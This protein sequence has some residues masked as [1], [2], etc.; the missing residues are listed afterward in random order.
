MSSLSSPSNQHFAASHRRIN[1][2]V[3]GRWLLALAATPLLAGCLS[4]EGDSDDGYGIVGWDDG[5]EAGPKQGD[6]APNFRL[7]AL[8][9]PDRTLAGEVAAGLPV[10]LN[11]FATWCASC[12]A[13][14]PVLDAA[15]GVTATVIG[16]DLR[17]AAD[18]VRPLV[19]ETGIRYPIL[20]DRDGA[21]ARALNAIALPTTCV[22]AADGTI[23]RLIV[24]PLTAAS[25]AEGIGAAGG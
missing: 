11:V 10:V 7:M 23:R 15:H 6:R 3:A 2:R 22:L 8:D 24:G 14:M 18:R 9:G 16:I 25:L 4:N 13:E 12:R 21:V 20:L 5:A 1:R 19:A 17:E